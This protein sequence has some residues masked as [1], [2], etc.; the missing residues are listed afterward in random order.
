MVKEGQIFYV[1]THRSKMIY[2]IKYTYYF[3]CS[4]PRN[5]STC[6]YRR[7]ACEY[8]SQH[9]RSFNQGFPRYKAP[10]LPTWLQYMFIPV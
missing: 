7:M 8:A 9:S 2:N 6:A 10:V 3:A 1:N 5:I 4:Y